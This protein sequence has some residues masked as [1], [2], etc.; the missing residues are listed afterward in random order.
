VPANVAVGL[1]AALAARFDYV[2]F[3]PVN[4]TDQRNTF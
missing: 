1:K 4:S 3:N 2:R